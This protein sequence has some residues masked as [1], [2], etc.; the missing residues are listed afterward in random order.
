MKNEASKV[1]RTFMIGLILIF[2]LG[3]LIPSP[4]VDAS[5]AAGTLTQ[6]NESVFHLELND[7]I[8]GSLD[9]SGQLTLSDENGKSE[10]FPVE[11]QDKNDDKVKLV[12]KK[13]SDGYDIQV[14]KLEE[15][16]TFYKT[17]WAKCTLG[18]AGGLGT[19]VLGGGAAGSVIP[20]LGTGAGMVL[21]GVSGAATGAA[22][23]CF[24]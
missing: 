3:I 7:T 15:G 17:N 5:E 13:V 19:G 8:K 22:A 20:A 14:I 10:K 12:Y 4:K 11:A 2:S 6:K 23:S 21:G 9:E 1:T 24:D 18:T 16:T